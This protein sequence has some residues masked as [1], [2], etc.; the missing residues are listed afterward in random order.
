MVAKI[1]VFLSL[2]IAVM[3]WV[4]YG[5]ISLGT[6]RK[7]MRSAYRFAIGFNMPVVCVSVGQLRMI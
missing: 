2:E 3:A 6:H 7:H 1:G 5:T 4:P